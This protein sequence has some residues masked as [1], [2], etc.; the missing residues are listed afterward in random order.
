MASAR[1]VPH[2]PDLIDASEYDQHPDGWLV[3]LR[4]SA[5]AEGITILGDAFGPRHWKRC[6]LS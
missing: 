6:S 5:T 3:R 4:L 2:L 1:Y